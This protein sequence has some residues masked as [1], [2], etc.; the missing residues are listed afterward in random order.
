M[1]FAAMDKAVAD[2]KVEFVITNPSHYIILAHRNN[3]SRVVTLNAEGKDL[4]GSG[5]GGVIAVKS[6]RKDLNDLDDLKGK[7]IACP[8]EASLGGFQLQ[9]IT[10]LD[11]GINPHSDIS[12]VFTGMPHDKAVLQVVNGKADGAFIRTSVIESMESEGLIKKDSL[13]IIHP[14]TFPDFP[15]KVSTNLVPDWPLSILPHVNRSLGRQVTLALLTMDKKDPAA[16]AGGYTSWSIPADYL[17]VRKVLERLRL[18]P[19]D[20]PIPV[21]LADIIDSYR[22]QG[23]IFLAG[24]LG[25][26]LSLLYAVIVAGKLRF[27]TNTLNAITASMEEG[28]YVTDLK[29]RITFSNPAAASLLG[30]NQSELTGAVAHDLFHKHKSNEFLSATECPIFKSLIDLKSY[31]GETFFQKKDG[32]IIAVQIT[33]NLLRRSGHIIGIINV[34]YDISQRKLKEKETEELNSR[35]SSIIDAIPDLMFEIDQDGLFYDF[36]SPEPDLLLMPPDQF[37]GKTIREVMPEDAADICMNAVKEALKT[38][39]SKG[40]IYSLNF[41]TGKKWFELSIAKKEK[42]DIT[43]VHLIVLVRDITVRKQ[44]ELILSNFNDEL[45]KTVEKEV[46]LRL[47]SEM[48]YQT[49]FDYSPEGILLVDKSG[50]IRRCNSAAE[51][52]LAYSA[53]ELLSKSIIDLSPEI[54]PLTGKLSRDLV[55]IKLDNVFKGNSEQLEWT[56]FKKNREQLILQT[57]LA[58]FGEEGEEVL[59]LW[60][61]NSELKRLQNE[62]EN[63]QAYL[64]QSAKQAELGNLIGMIAHQW[65]QPLNAIALMAQDLPDALASGELKIA[66]LNDYIAKIMDQISFMSGTM[67]DFRRFYKPSAD[68]ALFDP[69]KECEWILDLFSKQ[70]KVYKIN[71]EVTGDENLLILGNASEFKQVILNII[72]NA[73]D[74]LTEKRIPEPVIKITIK[75][76]EDHVVLYVCDNGGGIKPELLPARIFEPFTTTKGEKGTGIGLS[77][78]RIIIVEKMQGTLRAYNDESG[79][80]FEISLPQASTKPA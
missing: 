72:N 27:Q 79:A 6:D 23:L 59:V 18:P 35:L 51:N 67:N 4:A 9:A 65:T 49:L 74:V 55:K 66:D 40:A 38:G 14:R 16:V 31:Q 21:T 80:C 28:L 22:V 42:T 13:K 15:Y 3:I 53:G 41:P 60:R 34:F 71:I 77:L 25:L 24:L 75:Q 17:P 78:S 36:R 39:H 8:E 47:K 32:S 61:D 62:R 57:L 68:K 73:K 76:K 1:D 29:G 5:F 46:G 20:H 7:I 54:Q 2:G 69:R 33:G 45:L 56:V 19:F 58:P 70:F 26:I 44:H 52:L 11:H 63:Q 10:L 30:Y 37:I 64:M 43:T 50:V 48:I 12:L